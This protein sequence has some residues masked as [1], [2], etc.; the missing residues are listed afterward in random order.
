MA[1]PAAPQLTVEHR[2]TLVKASTAISNKLG[3]RI[4]RLANSNTVPD[5]YE[6]LNAVVYLTSSACS[7]SYVSR[8]AR[9]ASFV[10]VGWD[11]RSGVSGGGQTA[12]DMAECGFYSLGDADHVK[13]F[14]CDLGLR[15]WIRG[16]S[17]EREHAKFSPL[18]FYLKSCLGLDGLQAVTPQTT[19]YP[20]SYT[21]QDHNQLMRTIGEDFC[22]PVGRVACGVG[23]DD[24]KVLLALARN[25]IR[26]RKR[27]SAKELILS[28]QSEWQRELLNNPSDP[29]QF[30]SGFNLAAVFRE[31]YRIIAS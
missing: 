4:N 5:F 17:P 2:Q 23:L 18:C 1:A 20:A 27:Y 21:R 14:F 11:N 15:D 9:M 12:E 28:A 10:R 29:P 24:T 13:C 22:G 3:A 26:F 8:E 6:A 7:L 31:F 16:D 30:L 19:N 25:F